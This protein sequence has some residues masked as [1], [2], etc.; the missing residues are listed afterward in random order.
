MDWLKSVREN[1]QKPL[2]PPV[3]PEGVECKKALNTLIPPVTP[4]DSLLFQKERNILEGEKKYTQMEE[5]VQTSGGHRGNPMFYRGNDELS[6]RGDRGNQGKTHV[7]EVEPAE[8]P[9]RQ[10]HLT[11]D[12]T[13]VIPFDS[14]PKYHWWKG[15]QSVKTTLAEVRSRIEVGSDGKPQ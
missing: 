2:I 4:C 11:A 3:P 5:K 7:L 10:P 14:D 1:T 8:R 12:G 9:L 6:L 15:G 13:L